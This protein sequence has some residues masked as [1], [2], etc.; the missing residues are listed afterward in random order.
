M[1]PSKNAAREAL[2]D[3]VQVE[4]DAV[5][6]V[7]A[8]ARDEVSSAETRQEGKYDTRATEASYL[9]RGQAWRVAALRR[10]RAWFDL[11]VPPPEHEGVVD[12]GSLVALAR[13]ERR[14]LVLL[15]PSGGAT[16]ELDGQPLLGISPRSPL[17]AAM[18]GLE[19]DDAFEVRTPGGV[20]SWEILAVDA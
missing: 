12:V 1:L 8:M 7:A 5:E 6:R 2:R 11:P 17:G 18:M 16:T 15:L 3:A 13:G 9:A 10:L 19:A 14:S 4:L 20:Q